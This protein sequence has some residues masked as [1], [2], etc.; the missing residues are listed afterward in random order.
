MKMR[1]KKDEPIVTL[2]DLLNLI[3]GENYKY[4]KMAE[5]I[6]TRIVKKG[7]LEANEWISIVLE[8]IANTFTDLGNELFDLYNALRNNGASNYIIAQKLREF[9]QD[10][11]NEHNIP[12]PFNIATNS[13]IR[14]LKKM[15]QLGLIYRKNKRYYLSEQFV[16]RLQ[17]IVNLWSGYL[18]KAEKSFYERQKDKKKP[19]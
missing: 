2:D 10:Y 8:D 1:I 13:Y 12:N 15:K 14:A 11:A 5:L 7:Y 9:C 17:E 18:L 3:F 16:R 6:I 19:Q 4:K